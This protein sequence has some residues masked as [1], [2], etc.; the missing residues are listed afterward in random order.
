[1]ST[2]TAVKQYLSSIGRKGG[3]AGG[4]SQSEPK[5]AAA[6]AN[7]AKGGRPR[8]NPKPLSEQQ[9]EESELKDLRKANAFLHERLRKETL[10]EPRQRFLFQFAEKLSGQALRAAWKTHAAIIHPDRGGDAAQASAFNALYQELKKGRLDFYES[11]VTAAKKA[12][13]EN[14]KPL[15]ADGVVELKE[16]MVISIAGQRYKLLADDVAGFRHNPADRKNVGHLKHVCVEW[17]PKTAEQQNPK[18]PAKEPKTHSTRIINGR[19]MTCCGKHA[20]A[21]VLADG[22]PTCKVCADQWTKELLAAHY[23]KETQNSNPEPLS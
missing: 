3:L 2:A 21:A 20:A 17:L 16:G 8:K 13:Q 23:A 15:T 11:P 14:P 7:G 6:R 19:T 22:K 5:A 10:L 4:K 12:E 18:P 1:M 9:R